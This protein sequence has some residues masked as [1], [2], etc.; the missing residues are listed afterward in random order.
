MTLQYT[1]GDSTSCPGNVK[2][3]LL[4]SLVCSPLVPTATSYVDNATVFVV[5][6][7]VAKCAYSVTLPSLYGCPTA[8]VTGTSICN[9]NGACGFNLAAGASQCYCYTGFEGATCNQRAASTS[10]GSTSVETVLLVIVLI[11]LAGV[12]GL[13]GY[14]AYK[15]RRLIIKPDAYKQMEGKCTYHPQHTRVPARVGLYAL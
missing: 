1:G 8:C 10:G 7:S 9:G 12:L 3:R 5:E 15:L 6:N 4:L 14:M 2:R 11:V 13:I